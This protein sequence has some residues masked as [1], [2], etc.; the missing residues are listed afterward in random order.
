MW[1][2]FEWK[3]VFS[4]KSRDSTSAP[5]SFAGYFFFF[6]SLPFHF[7][8]THITTIYVSYIDVLL[9]SRA[10]LRAHKTRLEY[11]SLHSLAFSVCYDNT[12]T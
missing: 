10:F 2:M 12:I 9:A 5:R 1:E 4:I 6:N 8:T 3:Q 11:L 7:L